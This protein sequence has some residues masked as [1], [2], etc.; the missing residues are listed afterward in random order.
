MFICEF[1]RFWQLK[2]GLVWQQNMFPVS[3]DPLDMSLVPEGLA[4]F[5]YRI[6]LWLLSCLLEFLLA[7]LQQ[8]TMLKGSDYPFCVLML[9]SLRPKAW[10]ERVFGCCLAVTSSGSVWLICFV[11]KKFFLKAEFAFVDITKSGNL[12]WPS[13]LGSTPSKYARLAAPFCS[14]LY[15]ECSCRGRWVSCKWFFQLWRKINPVLFNPVPT[16]TSTDV[17]QNNNFLHLPEARCCSNWA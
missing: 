3:F 10:A 13:S 12:E 2:R 14:W 4:G 8:W 16:D 1:Y 15:L 9:H 17:K 5:L 7:F 6:V 11:L